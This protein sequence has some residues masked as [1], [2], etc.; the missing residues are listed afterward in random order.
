VN[1]DDDYVEG[2]TGEEIIEDALDQVAAKLRGDCNLRETDAYQGGY[3]GWF[4]VHLN[5]RGIDLAKVDTRIIVSKPAEAGATPGETEQK[6][7]DLRV[8]IPLEPRLNV[9]R[10]R[11]GQEVP[12]LTKDEEGRPVVKKRRYARTAAGGATGE[13]LG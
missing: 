9:V 12:T 8:D 13:S 5:L 1:G 11:S 2:L 6:T 4:E 7:V 10:E 3:D